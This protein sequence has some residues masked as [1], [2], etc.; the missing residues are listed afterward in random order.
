MRCH[1][2]DERT[3]RRTHEQWKVEQYS[4]WAESAI[5]LRGA[6]TSRAKITF[7]QFLSGR[8]FGEF[9]NRAVSLV[10]H[11]HLQAIPRRKGLRVQNSAIWRKPGDDEQGYHDG[12]LETVKFKMG[13]IR[14]GIRMMRIRMR[15]LR[16]CLYGWG[17]V[18]I[19]E[20]LAV[21]WDYG[22]QAGVQFESFIRRSLGRGFLLWR[23]ISHLLDLF[24]FAIIALTWLI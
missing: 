7:V 12:A 15:I 14:T 3:D 4:V 19:R 18:Q 1:A 13:L 22:D 10:F 11:E 2:C 8:D 16:P 6:I 20:F 9:E 21:C 5:R 23:L 17:E 24:L